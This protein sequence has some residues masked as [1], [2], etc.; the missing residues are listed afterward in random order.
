MA[1]NGASASSFVLVRKMGG[2]TQPAARTV[3]VRT[4]ISIVPLALVVAFA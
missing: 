4:M 2:D 1:T 3:V